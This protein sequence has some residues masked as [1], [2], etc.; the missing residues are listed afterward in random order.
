MAQKGLHRRDQVKIMKWG[1]EGEL[2]RWTQC[3]LEGYK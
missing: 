1:D 3:N 2:S